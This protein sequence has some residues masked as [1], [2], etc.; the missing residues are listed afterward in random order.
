MHSKL[1]FRIPNPLPWKRG[2]ENVT[3]QIPDCTLYFQTH[4]VVAKAWGCIVMWRE[5]HFYSNATAQMSMLMQA[6]NRWIDAL[7]IIITKQLQPR[8][9]W[10]LQAVPNKGHPWLRTAPFFPLSHPDHGIKSVN[11]LPMTVSV[12]CLSDHSGTSEVCTLCACYMKCA[13]LMILSYYCNIFCKF[14]CINK[15]KLIAL[16]MITVMSHCHSWLLK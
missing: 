2:T 8:S 5:V 7:W 11:I 12:S 6:S 4:S 10:K 14:I 1:N 3:V 15:Y 9:H 16:F 13:A